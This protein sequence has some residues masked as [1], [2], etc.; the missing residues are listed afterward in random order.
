MPVLR[1]KTFEDLD[2]YEREGKGISW[3]FAPDEAYFQRAL[4]FRVRV[5]IPPGIY[6]FDTLVKAQEWER[7]R[8]VGDGTAR[9]TA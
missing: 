1:F 4:R 6:R 2:R 7:Q 3:C 9:R 5:P 8:W